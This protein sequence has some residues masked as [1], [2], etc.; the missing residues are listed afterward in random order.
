[1]SGGEMRPHDMARQMAGRGHEIRNGRVESVQL[2]TLLTRSQ[3]VWRD[4]KQER[5]EEDE[6]GYVTFK[7]VDWLGD[8]QTASGDHVDGIE[9]EFHD[10]HGRVTPLGRVTRLTSGDHRATASVVTGKGKYKPLLPTDKRW[11]PVVGTIERAIEA[12][13][14]RKGKKWPK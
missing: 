1:M 7:I 9:V 2:G 4:L 13:W 5:F 6:H 14:R 11:N 8:F 10:P 3:Q 12:C